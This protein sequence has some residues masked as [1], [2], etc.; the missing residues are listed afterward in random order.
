MLDDLDY[1]DS[2]SP[3]I[4]LVPAGVSWEDVQDHIK[5]AHHPMLMVLD[6]GDQYAG[7]YWAGTRAVVTGELGADP[8]EAVVEFRDILRERGEA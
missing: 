2:D 1:D 5:I 3:S 4:A 6:G 8:D 7:V